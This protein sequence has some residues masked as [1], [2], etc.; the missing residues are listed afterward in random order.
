MHKFDL[1]ITDDFFK[2]SFKLIF[3]YKNIELKKIYENWKR[4]KFI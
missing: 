1:L 2:M 3:H 4:E